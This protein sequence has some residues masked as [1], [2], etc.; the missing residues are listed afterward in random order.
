MKHL[1][2]D[3]AAL[4]AYEDK[5][6]PGDLV[7]VGLYARFADSSTESWLISPEDGYV[8]MVVAH[9]EANS[10]WRGNE[11]RGEVNVMPLEPLP[12]GDDYASLH[13]LLV[14]SG[15]RTVHHNGAEVIL[16]RTIELI[17]P[18]RPDAVPDNHMQAA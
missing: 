7:Y 3:P 12:R 16:Y 11:N 15:E 8:G 14:R 17:T 18:D 13:P 9:P 10:N 2:V 5:L 1:D 4:M 6:E